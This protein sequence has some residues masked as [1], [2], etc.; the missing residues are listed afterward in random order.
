VSIY[1]SKHVVKL[2]AY[3]LVL[4]SGDHGTIFPC[5]VKSELFFKI[6]D[7]NSHTHNN[8]FRD[9]GSSGPTS[10]WHSGWSKTTRGSNGRHPG[11]WLSPG[12]PG[13]RSRPAS[14]SAGVSARDR[15]E[16]QG[17]G[18]Y[19]GLN[20][21]FQPNSLTHVSLSPIDEVGGRPDLAR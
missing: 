10:C 14:R 11:L 17:L 1:S 9:P 16:D 15:G 2:G 6:Q 13:P 4:K 3:V 5:S 12:H 21:R 8:Q 20:L 19:Y 7:I 18:P